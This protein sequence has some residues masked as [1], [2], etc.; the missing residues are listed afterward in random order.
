MIRTA[1]Y[2]GDLSPL[3]EWALQRIDPR[4]TATKRADPPPREFMEFVAGQM[5]HCVKWEQWS[6]NNTPETRLEKGWLHGF[7]HK[8]AWEPGT[9]TMICY[10]TKCEGGAIELADD[11]TMADA[12]SVY[13]EPGLCVLVSPEVWHGVRPIIKGERTTVIVTGHPAKN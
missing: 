2:G 3:F 10:L 8:H 4:S 12:Q 13:P 5:P 7:P 6:A 11:E 1:H 9:I